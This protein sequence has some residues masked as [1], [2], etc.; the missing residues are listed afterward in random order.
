MKMILRSRF[1]YKDGTN[2]EMSVAVPDEV[3]DKIAV[4]GL[5]YIEVYVDAKATNLSPVKLDKPMLEDFIKKE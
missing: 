4:G 2:Y 3:G 1:W 5:S